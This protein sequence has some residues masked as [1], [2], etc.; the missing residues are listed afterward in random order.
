M[1]AMRFAV[2]PLDNLNLGAL[3]VSPLIGW[4]QDDLYART[5]TR[6]HAA[7][8]EHLRATEDELPA[9]AMEALR[10][11]LAMADFTTP[12]LFLETLLPVPLAGRRTLLSR[13]GREAPAPGPT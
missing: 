7:I 4:T 1:A 9:A 12:F 13:F 2:Q 6:G 3:L 10:P 11:L 5:R 8:W